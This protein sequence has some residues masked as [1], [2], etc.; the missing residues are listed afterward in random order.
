MVM[1]DMV[2][3]KVGTKVDMA[4]AVLDTEAVM[5]SQLPFILSSLFFLETICL[6]LRVL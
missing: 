3:T 4:I 1:A 5:V 6:M 2:G